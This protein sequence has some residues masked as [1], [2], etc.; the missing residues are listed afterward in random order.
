MREIPPANQLAQICYKGN[1]RVDIYRKASIYF[2]RQAL[3]IGMRANHI[4]ALRAIFLSIGLALFAKG[5]IANY[6]MAVFAYQIALFL[7][8]MDGAIARYNKESSFLGEAMDFAL[9]HLSSTIIY[10]VSAG[11]LA[12]RT[13]GNSA[14]LWMSLI[15]CALAQSAAFLR[16]LYSEHKVHTEELKKKSAL[17]R[18]FHQDNMRLLLFALTITAILTPW[19]EYLPKALAQ[20]Y[21]LFEIIKNAYLFS[22]LWIESKRFPFSIRNIKIYSISAIYMASTLASKKIRNRLR[23]KLKEKYKESPLIEQ[24]IRA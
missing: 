21:L 19:A 22:K 3:R 16:A 13:T 15:T 17:L 5:G 20:S 1:K 18:F 4:T 7:D 12:L 14:F 6:I 23:A 9:D 10:F 24:I 2:T 8:T 11:I